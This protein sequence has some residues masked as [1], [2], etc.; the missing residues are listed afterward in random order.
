MISNPD[1]IHYACIA[2]KTT[3]L[4]E[5]ARQPDLEDLARRC[6]EKTPPYHSM[7]CHT[8]R[9][10]TYTFL[11]DDPFVYF[12][13]SDQD[14]E[15]SDCLWFL[16]RVKSGFEEAARGGSKRRS[17]NLVSRSFQP[18]FDS[19]LREI[20]ASDLNSVN[21]TPSLSNE[22]QTPS[23]DGSRG[24]SLAF[25]PLLG[26][27][28]CNGLKKKKRLSGEANADLGKD[29]SME[30]AVD[31]YDDVNRDFPTPAQKNISSYAGDRQ[32]AKQVW[33][34]HVWVVLLL[35][36]FVCAVL[37]GIWLWVC[38]GFKCVES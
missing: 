5:F 30:N 34:K 36:L 21:S 12:A 22:S 29:S 18:E 9:R 27:K 8:V 28:L 6:I 23:L 3:V 26:A 38:R 32:K 33:R 15:Q 4:A 10:R 37:F 25:T 11:I 14:L 1:L 19:I 24:Q 16:N 31:V 7:F 20:M 35:D 13:I 2:R 17:E